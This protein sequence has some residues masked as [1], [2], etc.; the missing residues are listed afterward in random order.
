MKFAVKSCYDFLAET[1]QR[2]LDDRGLSIAAEASFY[3]MFSLFPLLFLALS[4]LGWVKVPI[5]SNGWLDNFYRVISAYIPDVPLDVVTR[6]LQKLVEQY[7]GKD[8]VLAAVVFTWPASSAFHVYADAVNTA[9]DAPETRS[10]LEYRLISFFLLF[11][12][13]VIIFVTALIFSILPIVWTAVPSGLLPGWSPLVLYGVRFIGALMILVP[14]IDLIYR[15]GP[16]V[17]DPDSHVVWPGAIFSG[18]L[19]L[20]FS[21]LF[22]L[23]IQFLDT[24]RFLYGTLGGIMLLML[25]LYL[26]S[27]AVVLGAEFNQVWLKRVRNKAG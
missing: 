23:Y 14:A 7:S 16:K 8:V 20:L 15:F 2:F 24:Y 22:G 26:V 10:Y 6:N 19:W 11:A 4:V 27:T 25:W 3:L 12:S 1:V 9:Y 13:G 21:E 5:E 18:V 17:A